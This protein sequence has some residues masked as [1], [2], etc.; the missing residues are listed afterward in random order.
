RPLAD[1]RICVERLRAVIFPD[2]VDI[3]CSRIL[4]E[5][6]R[7]PI[8]GDIHIIRAPAYQVRIAVAGKAV[9]VSAKVEPHDRD[10][11]LVVEELDYL[12]QAAISK[13]QARNALAASWDNATLPEKPKPRS[14]E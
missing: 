14:G 9:K 7:D 4:P 2:D 1:K 10:I 5:Y 6:H 12:V 11:R 3:E 8:D 13:S